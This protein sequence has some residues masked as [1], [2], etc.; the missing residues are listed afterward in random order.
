MLEA[1]I[2]LVCSIIFVKYFGI[3]GV[4]IAGI[5][6]SL[7]L[8][9]YSYP[10]YVYTVIFKRKY[11]SFLFE[12]FKLLILMLIMLGV[13]YLL[14]S[15]ISVNNSLLQFVI[16]GVIA[17]VVVNLIFYIIFKENRF[18]YFK[19]LFGSLIKKMKLKKN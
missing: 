18:N 2:N 1:V 11:C 13:T 12:Q 3:A 19:T 5:V 6:S 15:V 9:L 16:N 8:F 17:L 7:L 4:F 10:K 14:I